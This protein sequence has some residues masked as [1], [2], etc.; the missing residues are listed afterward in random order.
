M[1][2]HQDR[3][4]HQRT[5]KINDHVDKPSPKCQSSN[6]FLK[7]YPTQT[8]KPSSFGKSALYSRYSSTGL[9]GYSFTSSS[10]VF[11]ADKSL[12]SVQLRAHV[13]QERTITTALRA[14]RDALW[15]G[16][17]MNPPRIPPTPSEAQEIRRSA[18][19]A[20]LNALPRTLSPWS[21]PFYSPVLPVF[22]FLWPFG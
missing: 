21:L 2:G 14:T 20:A 22:P 12:M 4:G 9:S 5:M 3:Q 13:F 6:S 11:L 8:D 10:R 15:P 19:K 18:E 1:H 7:F 16:G 17:I